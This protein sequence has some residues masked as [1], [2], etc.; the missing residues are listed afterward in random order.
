M[1]ADIV[2][3]S[4]THCNC[5]RNLLLSLFVWV[6]ESRPEIKKPQS[7]VDCGFETLV[8]PK[9]LEPLIQARGIC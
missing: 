6:L 9:G 3:V 8:R 4:R 2:S 5:S 1:I 7:V